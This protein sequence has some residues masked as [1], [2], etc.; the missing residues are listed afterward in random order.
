MLHHGSIAKA[1]PILVRFFSVFDSENIQ[2]FIFHFT[3]KVNEES[4]TTIHVHNWEKSAFQGK[5][6]FCQKKNNCYNLR[7]DDASI[8]QTASRMGKE[9]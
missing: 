2:P 5:G 9:F 6:F 7:R 1:P 3:L 8:I 4:T